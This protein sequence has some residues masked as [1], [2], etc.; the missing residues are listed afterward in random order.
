[1]IYSNLFNLKKAVLANTCRPTPKEDAELTTDKAIRTSPSWEGD[2]E[3]GVL[4][5][6][7]LAAEMGFQLGDI[8]TALSVEHE[9]AKYKINRFK[10]I[11]AGE[12]VARD[13]R[14]R[15]NNKIMLIKN[16]LRLCV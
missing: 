4:L 13:V 10:E 6:V 2:S 9:E 5:Y 12:N 3:I 7:G 1:M 14:W 15:L 16:Y 8:T 11:V